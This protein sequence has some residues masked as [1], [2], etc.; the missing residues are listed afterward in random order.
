MSV[1]GKNK[2][3]NESSL[4]RERVFTL[5][6]VRHTAATNDVFIIHPSDRM[7]PVQEIRGHAV[8]FI[9]ASTSSL[10]SRGIVCT[11]S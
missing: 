9:M 5:S 8:A 1:L 4:K 10:V 11:E 2:K 6:F 3:E 7:T